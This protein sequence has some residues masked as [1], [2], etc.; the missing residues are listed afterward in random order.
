M[1][2]R[3]RPGNHNP[4][5]VI[6]LNRQFDRL[7]RGR[8]TTSIKDKP[9]GGWTELGAETSPSLSNRKFNLLPDRYQRGDRLYQMQVDYMYFIKQ[10]SDTN[11]RN[12][13]LIK[14][15]QEHINRCREELGANG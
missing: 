1:N 5:P 6:S 2:D 12:T 7:M 11:G 14:N 3:N 15:C 10:V 9:V 4:D 13:A 8:P